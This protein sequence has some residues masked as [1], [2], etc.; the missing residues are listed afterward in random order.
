MQ[1]SAS[2][3]EAYKRAVAA[4]EQRRPL[5]CS[6]GGN[7]PDQILINRLSTQ[8]SD[9]N[10]ISADGALIHHWSGAMLIPNVRAQDVVTLLQDYDHHA[11]IYGPE[12]RSS[13]LLDKQGARYHVLH[14]SLSRNLITVGLKIES[15]IEWSGDEQAGF[16]SHSHTV[17]VTEFEHAGTP[18]AR[19]RTPNQAKGWMW[20]E[21]SWW[22]VI[23]E[24]DGACVTYETIALTRDIPWGWGW[25]VRSTIERFPA[26]TLSDMLDRTRYAVLSRFCR[27][28]HDAFPTTNNSLEGHLRSHN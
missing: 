4:V 7:R 5:F 23:S 3:V 19:E 6:A 18:R 26:K 27:Q 22:H 10:P 8:D 25:L 16:S 24:A 2:A 20:S 14:E 1:P 9:G 21:D 15:V 12:V 17:R 11:E 13:K 28:D